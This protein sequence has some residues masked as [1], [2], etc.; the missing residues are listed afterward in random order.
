[1]AHCTWAGHLS[2]GRGQ[3]FLTDLHGTC[4]S[5]EV[6]HLMRVSTIQSYG[7]IQNHL[8]DKVSIILDIRL[9]YQTRHWGRSRA[10]LEK[11]ISM[12]LMLDHSLWEND[13]YNLDHAC[14]E[15]YENRA[16]NR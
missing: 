8:V 10:L 7:S 6:S 15:K 13:L 11:N 12:K 9:E 14:E 16:L 2:I 4:S 3:S 5:E 1:M